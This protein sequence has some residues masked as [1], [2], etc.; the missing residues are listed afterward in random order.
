M[1]YDQDIFIHHSYTSHG[2]QRMGLWI[3]VAYDI[4]DNKVRNKVARMLRSQ[5]F[6]RLSRSVYASRGNTSLGERI[7]EK[8]RRLISEEDIAHIFIIREEDYYRTLVITKTSISR[9]YERRYGVLSF[10]PSEDPDDLVLCEARAYYSLEG[11]IGGAEPRLFFTDT[12]REKIFVNTLYKV[13]TDKGF[14]VDK[15]PLYMVKPYN[16]NYILIGKPDLVIE[17]LRTPVIIEATLTKAGQAW[18]T[19]CRLALYAL[20]YKTLYGITPLTLLVSTHNLSIAVYTNY[21]NYNLEKILWKIHTLQ[22]KKITH[23]KPTTNKNLCK[24]CRYKRICI[25]NK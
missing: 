23:L 7:A 18:Y 6:T 8:I 3:V 12:Y 16:Y 21:K 9:E 11:V 2:D 19:G 15:Q 22:H 4:H 14:Q 24:N 1:R 25:Y 10:N 13:L 20:M 5:G 17:S